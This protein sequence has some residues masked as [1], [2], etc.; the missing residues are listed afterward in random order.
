[1]ASNRSYFHSTDEKKHGLI[2]FGDE[3]SIVFEG[4]GSIVVNN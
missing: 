3:S 1:M 4:K 2:R